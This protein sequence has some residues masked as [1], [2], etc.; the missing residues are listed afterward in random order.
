[1]WKKHKKH[2][3]RRKAEKDAA[4][5]KAADEKPSEKTVWKKHKKH[6]RKAAAKA[7][8]EAETEAATRALWTRALW[9]RTNAHPLSVEHSEKGASCTKLGGTTVC[10]APTRATTAALASS[11]PLPATNPI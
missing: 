6:K 5:E 8:A 3:R 1:M 4:A 11:L 9:S 10:E 2:Q 7:A